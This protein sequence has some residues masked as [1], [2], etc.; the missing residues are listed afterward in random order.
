[1]MTEITYHI[2]QIY[3]I[4]TYMYRIFMENMIFFHNIQR[5]TPLAE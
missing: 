3:V 1:M 4:I 5:D 2:S